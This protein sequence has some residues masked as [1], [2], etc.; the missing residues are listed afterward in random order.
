VPIFAKILVGSGLLLLVAGLI[1][2]LGARVFP[3][4]VPGGIAFKSGNTSV[5][6]P[7]VS[8]ILLSIVVTIVLNVV[9]R[10]LR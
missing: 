7:I 6:F 4:G 3:G 1:F 8:S 2:A 5:Y 9:L 10:F